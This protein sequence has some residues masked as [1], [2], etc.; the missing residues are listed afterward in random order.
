MLQDAI[1]SIRRANEAALEHRQ[2]VLSRRRPIRLLD[3][4]VNQV[5]TLIERNDPVVPES[6]IGEIGRFIGDLDPL[7]YRRMRRSGQDT[8]TRVLDV[9]FEAEGQFLPRTDAALRRR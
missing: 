7:M 1:M 8:A 5:E 9:L 4:W 2:A 3:H 6:L